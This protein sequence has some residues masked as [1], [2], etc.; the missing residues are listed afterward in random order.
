MQCAL[1]FNEQY[2]RGGIANMQR[3]F[4][5][6]HNADSIRELMVSSIAAF[7]A[8]TALIDR[9]M[10]ITYTSFGNSLENVSRQISLAGISHGDC[11]AIDGDG[12]ELIILTYAVIFAGACAVAIPTDAAPQEKKDIFAT[13]CVTVLLSKQPNPSF[14]KAAGNIS[15]AYMVDAFLLS[16]PETVTKAL[17][18]PQVKNP[19]FIRFTSG[20]TGKSKGVLFTERSLI[21]RIVATNKG[22]KITSGDVVIWMFP[23]AYHFIVSIMLYLYAGACI[24]MPEDH[25]PDSIRDAIM[26]HQGT[27]LYA[28]EHFFRSLIANCSKDDLSSVRMCFSTS[29]GLSEKTAVA[30]Y[31]KFEIPLCQAYGIIEVGLPFVNT[32]KPLEKMRSVGKMLPDYQIKIIDSHGQ[33]AKAGE[34]GEVLL[35]GP[36]FFDAYVSSAEK[37]DDV[38]PDGWFHSGDIG[39]MDE[40]GYLYLIG[41]QKNIINCMG[42]KI[43][44]SE[45]E[46]ILNRHPMIKESLVTAKP[47]NYLHEIPHA[48]IVLKEPDKVPEIGT[49][50]A[51][52]SRQLAPYKIP[53]SYKFIRVLPRTGS[54][55]I[56]RV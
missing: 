17:L 48:D 18:P 7:G 51:F 47:H 24:V 49:L 36:G 6:Q 40:E 8:K 31:R 55:K 44:P 28:N 34:A 37:K 23:L 16:R 52:C 25:T 53:R 30:F 14:P 21:E 22:L 9:S 38:C 26:K 19:A 11:V 20:T 56:K 27:V 32:E 12:I 35:K 5:E 13:C 33:R 42:M 4:S 15:D 39:N 54:D 50:I 10:S 2:F 1:I 3:I 29:V 46:E 45:V 41:R 43:F